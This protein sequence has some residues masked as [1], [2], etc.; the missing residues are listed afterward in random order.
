MKI[1]K[2]IRYHKQ[3]VITADR[4]GKLHSIVGTYCEN[5]EYR[6]ELKDESNVTFDSF[7]ELKEYCNS[8]EK[9]IQELEI[10]GRSKNIFRGENTESNPKQDS[11]TEITIHLK[12]IHNSARFG[13]FYC[14]SSF[15]NQ[16]SQVL[17]EKELNEFLQSATEGHCQFNIWRLISAV[18]S[19][20][21]AIHCYRD[22]FGNEFKL[23][24]TI[25]FIIVAGLISLGLIDILDKYF[26]HAVEFAWGNELEQYRKRLDWRSKLIWCIIIPIAI[27][28]VVPYIQKQ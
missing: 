9:R 10:Y 27:A 1:E 19:A 16:D 20:W 23:S 4:L 8:G 21:V 15:I 28:I 5:I 12:N 3:L 17:F 25:V 11:C 2:T 18:V 7:V 14:F 13:M 26:Y 24:W 22:I 6:A